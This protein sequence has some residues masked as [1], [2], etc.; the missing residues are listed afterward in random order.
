MLRDGVGQK[1]ASQK[2]ALWGGRFWSRGSG[3]GV[4]KT[5]DA[6]VIFSDSFDGAFYI[7]KSMRHMVTGKN[8]RRFR[9][10][11]DGRGRRGVCRFWGSHCPQN[12]PEPKFLPPFG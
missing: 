4:A 9:V 6:R 8:I 1:T 12:L 10:F 7:A 11:T 2:W 5:I 3:R